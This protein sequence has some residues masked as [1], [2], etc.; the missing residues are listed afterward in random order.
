LWGAEMGEYLPAIA[1]GTG[2]SAVA[3]SAGEYHTCALLV[4]FGGEGSGLMMMRVKGRDVKTALSDTDQCRSS[5]LRDTAPA[6]RERG[7][8]G[9]K[10]VFDT[11][12]PYRDASVRYTSP[13]RLRHLPAAPMCSSR[14]IR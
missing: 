9:R 8:V 3:V 6:L 14:R 2:T 13:C 5:I 10:A 1:L 7:S 4:R 11:R 12:D